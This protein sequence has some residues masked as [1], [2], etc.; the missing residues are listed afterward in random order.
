M[1]EL[2]RSYHCSG[3]VTTAG[4]SR[5]LASKHNDSAYMDVYRTYDGELKLSFR[6]NNVDAGHLIIPNITETFK[7][8]IQKGSDFGA[9]YLDFEGHLPVFTGQDDA[10][11]FTNDTFSLLYN[12]YGPDDVLAIRLKIKLNRNIH[13]CVDVYLSPQQSQNFL[14]LLGCLSG[15]GVIKQRGGLILANGKI[16]SSSLAPS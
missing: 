2:L 14:E 13:P 7:Q 16:K 12:I 9:F 6:M 11:T 10:A 1:P 15:S 8:A 3:K 4:I 5:E